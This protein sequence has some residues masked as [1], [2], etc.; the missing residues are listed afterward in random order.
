MTRVL[1]SCS[2]APPQAAMS[3]ELP[4][5]GLLE[6]AP[7]QNALRSCTQKIHPLELEQLFSG[8]TAHYGR[9]RFLQDLT[10][11]WSSV[12]IQQCWP[13]GPGRNRG[14]AQLPV[15]QRM[16][17]PASSL[18]PPGAPKPVPRWLKVVGRLFCR[19][20]W[21]AAGGMIGPNWMS[22][23]VSGNT[24]RSAT[25]VYFNQRCT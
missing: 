14:Q 17:M 15:P 11:W 23:R 24:L 3:R 4:Q 2:T 21:W 20:S 1:R 10:A 16:P 12:C 25:F 6:L 8:E 19:A 7:A 18:Q 9:E 13:A 22:H 5:L